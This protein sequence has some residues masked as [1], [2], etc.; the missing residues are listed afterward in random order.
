M[1]SLAESIRM[2]E[3]GGMII[4]DKKSYNSRRNGLECVVT[5]E[6]SVTNDSMSQ[7]DGGSSYWKLKYEEMVEMNKTAEREFA[8]Y[9]E[10]CVQKESTRMQYVKSLEHKISSQSTIKGPASDEEILELRSKVEL[11]E[12]MT[13]M[14]MSLSSTCSATCTVRN[15][16][17]RKI[18]RFNI[19]VDGDSLIHFEPT[20]NVHLLPDFLQANLSTEAE[21]APELLINIFNSLYEETNDDA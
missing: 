12:V 1:A 15:A 21:H 16:A 9:R 18:T 11:Y 5:S 6:E 3:Q 20:G 4:I 17:Q 10:A 14:S 2:A 8:E 19:H 13:G 7:G